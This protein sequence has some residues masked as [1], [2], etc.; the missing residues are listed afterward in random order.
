MFDYYGGKASLARFYQ[1][2][3]HALIVEPF[4]GSAMYSM[5]HNK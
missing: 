4:A 1:C 3:R 5:Y 2:P